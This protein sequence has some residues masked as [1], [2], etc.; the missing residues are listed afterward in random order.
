VCAESIQ[1]HGSQLS[2]VEEQ[3]IQDDLIDAE[4][5]CEVPRELMWKWN[6]N[7]GFPVV[8]VP[9]IYM[10]CH[11]ISGFIRETIGPN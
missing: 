6:D 4:N 11:A 7:G 1:V 2:S 10:N 3:S 9:I 5:G 8:A